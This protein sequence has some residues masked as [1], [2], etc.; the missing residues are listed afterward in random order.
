MTPYRDSS[1]PPSRR[2]RERCDVCGL[3]LELVDVDALRMG[4]ATLMILTRRHGDFA[5]CPGR[6]RLEL[7]PWWLALLELVVG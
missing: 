7:V 5:R 2:A 3:E 6:P 1:P 4:A